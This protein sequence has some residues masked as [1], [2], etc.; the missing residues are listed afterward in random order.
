MSV[1]C[2]GEVA[3]CI[4]QPALFPWIGELEKLRSVSVSICLDS[5]KFQ[6]AGFLTRFRMIE[7]GSLR[8]LT[9][10]SV[11]ASRRGIIS[12]VEVVDRALWSDRLLTALAHWYRDAP[13]VDDVVEL[14]TTTLLLDLRFAVDY[15]EAAL[16][17]VGSYLELELPVRLRSSAMEATSVGSVLLRDLAAS[18]G[19]THYV[20]GPGS[21]GLEGH[22]LDVPMLARSGIV[23]LVMEYQDRRYEQG[24]EGFVPR[25]SVLDAIARLGPRA[26]ELIVSKPRI[27]SAA[28][29]GC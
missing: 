21:K 15:C 22:Y 16:A 10:P 9:F 5:V 20:F 4:N 23:P 24:F 13:Y 2:A 18:V 7:S 27:L 26:A 19:A 12:D 1:S 3:L 6:K 25:C 17:S 8:W 14:V 11:A 28:G 29:T